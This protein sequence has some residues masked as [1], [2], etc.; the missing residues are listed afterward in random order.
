MSRNVN[1]QHLELYLIKT[2][3]LITKARTF[4]HIYRT[5]THII[6]TFAHNSNPQ[7]LAIPEISIGGYNIDILTYILFIKLT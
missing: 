4:N 7:S 6:R 1:T 3:L 2:V 5:I